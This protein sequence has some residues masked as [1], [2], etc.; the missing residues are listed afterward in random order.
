MVTINQA[1]A[2]LGAY[3]FGLFV[4]GLWWTRREAAQRRHRDGH[5][6]QDGYVNAAGSDHAREDDHYAAYTDRRPEIA[7]LQP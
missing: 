4:F 1:L 6:N 3:F 2:V 7:S 5:S